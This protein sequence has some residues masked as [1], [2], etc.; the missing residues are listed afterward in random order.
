MSWDGQAESLVEQVIMPIA[1][2]NEMG[3]PIVDA[4]ARTPN[5][6]NTPK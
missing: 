4:L 5:T 2:V 3:L 6:P 1:N